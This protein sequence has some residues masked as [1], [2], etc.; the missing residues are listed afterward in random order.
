MKPVRVLVVDDDPDVA[1]YLSSFLEDHGCVVESA[2][3]AAQAVA[4]VEAF[5]PDALLVDVM[6]P[7]KSGLDL[8][9]TLRRDPRWSALPL[10]VITGSDQIVEDDGRSYMGSHAGVRGP[11][12]ML[13]KPV[14]RQ[15]LL[16]VLDSLCG[17][18]VPQA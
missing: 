5:H 10:V 17:G 13:A 3:S 2:A 12:G 16:E 18:L 15:A 7:G 14:D 6:L 8:V 9:V 11:D 4:A 1:D